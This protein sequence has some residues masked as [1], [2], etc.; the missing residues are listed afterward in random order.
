VILNG[1]VVPLIEKAKHDKIRERVAKLHSLFYNGDPLTL[2][3]QDIERM[4]VN[5]KAEKMAAYSKRKSLR[6]KV[7]WTVSDLNK[8]Q[9]QVNYRMIDPEYFGT[10]KP[11]FAPLDL[12]NALECMYTHMDIQKTSTAR[13]ALTWFTDTRAFQRG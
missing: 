13:R 10:T 4:Y 7:R 2:L 5:D 11:R 12:D 6:Y 3:E 1:S 9:D 8:H